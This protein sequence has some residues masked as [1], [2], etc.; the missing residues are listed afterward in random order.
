MQ[1]AIDHKS[2]CR[3]LAEPNRAGRT[4]LCPDCGEILIFSSPDGAEGADYYRCPGCDQP[5]N[6]GDK[7]G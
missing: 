7:N 4:P 1:P 6:G 3:M 5:V 2:R